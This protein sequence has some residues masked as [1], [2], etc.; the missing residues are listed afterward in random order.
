MRFP[1]VALPDVNVLAAK[2]AT[3]GGAL[4]RQL[5]TLAAW[6]AGAGRPVDDRGELRKADRRGLLGALGL[7]V[8]GGQ[9]EAPVLARLWG[10]AIEFDIIQL[11]H[12]RAVPGPGA[13]LLAGE[14]SSEQALDLWCALAD[15]LVQPSPP[16][17][18]AKDR[19]YLRDWLQP[20][21][22]RLL[23][24]LYAASAA[25]SPTDLN[26]ITAQLLDEYAYR[27]PAGAPD[28]FAGVAVTTVRL[29][30]AD[31]AH[32]GAV[33]VTVTGDGDEPDPQQVAAVATLGNAPSRRWTARGWQHGTE[34]ARSG[35]GASNVRVPLLSGRMR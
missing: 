17:N 20:W 4:L 1:P 22:P 12:A 26:A 18:A 34:S 25:A 9:A 5:T 30:L 14:A 29:A 16:G 27:L 31:L 6:V 13:D 19:E 8:G 2:V 33:T 24:L 3:E 35:A 23:G 15:E 11:R 28:L 10:L 7:P 21:M 32:H